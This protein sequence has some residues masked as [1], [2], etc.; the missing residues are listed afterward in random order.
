M[1]GQ[2][3][4]ED[5]YNL[6]HQYKRV[7]SGTAD[8]KPFRMVCLFDGDKAWTQFDGGEPIPM[9]PVSDQSSNFLFENLI[10]LH[11]LTLSDLKRSACEPARIEGRDAHCV[12]AEGDRQW[13]NWYFDKST[14]FL[15]AVKKIIDDPEQRQGQYLTTYSEFKNFEGLMLPTVSKVMI[16]GAPYFNVKVKQ[17]ELPKEIDPSVFV[18]DSRPRRSL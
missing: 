14:N 11:E 3:V 17:V 10:R 6:P 18:L 15:V 16:D 5:I 12:R 9:P 4:V 7:V 13:C 2:F 1:Q 8:G